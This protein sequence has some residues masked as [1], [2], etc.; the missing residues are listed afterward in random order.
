MAGTF[1]PYHKW[2]GIAADEQPANYY[3]FLGIRAFES[4][5]DVIASAADQRMVHVRSF[6]SGQY[7]ELSQRI[8]NELSAA[9][10]CLL[11][12]EK[13]AVYD[14]QLRSGSRSPIPSRSGADLEVPL[15]G[16]PPPVPVAQSS[17]PILPEAP[18]HIGALPDVGDHPRFVRRV[19][20]T[21]PSPA[22]VVVGGIGALVLIGAL[23]WIMAG[24]GQ[25]QPERPRAARD[26]AE[27]VTARHSVAATES[28]PHLDDD[29]NG[30]MADTTSTDQPE[31]S[32]PPD[33]HPAHIAP[34]LAVAPFA[35]EQ[36]ANHQETWAEH[37][38][39]P[40]EKTN[41]I[42]MK[43][44]LIPPGEFMIG[45]TSKEVEQFLQVAKQQ[46]APQ[47]LINRLPAEAPK[48][49]VRITR[50]FYLGIYEV[51]QAEYERVMGSNPSRFTCNPTRPVEQVIWSNAVEFCRIL[52][53][54]ES[55]QYR[56]PTEAEWEYACRAGTTTQWHF[57]DDASRLD[58]YAWFESNSARQTHPVGQ[59]KPNAWRLFDMYGNV[60][61]W[62]ADW[63]GLRYYANSPTDD[64]P[65]PS[66][67]SERV[68]RGG[69]WDNYASDCRSAARFGRTMS[70]RSITRGFRVVLAT[71]GN[72]EHSVSE[73]EAQPARSPRTSDLRMRHLPEP[74]GIPEES[75]ADRRPDKQ[76]GKAERKPVPATSD[77]Q[78][79]RRAIDRLYPE[80]QDRN[81]ALA[82]GNK[83]AALAEDTEE[84]TERF[85]LLRRASELSSDGG[86]ARRMLQLVGRIAEEFEVDRLLAQAAM[87]D[88]FAKKAPREE[89]IGALV[90]GSAG[91]IDEAIIAEQFDLADE[92]SALVY[93]ACQ[94]SAGREFR[95]DALARRR[96]V[97]GLRDEW[98]KV[99]AARAA[100]QSNPEDEAAHTAVGRWYGVVQA[101]WE[102]AL[103]HFA[104]GSDSGVRKLVD[105]ELNSAPEDAPAQVE[106]AD[107]WWDLAQAADPDSSPV[108]FVRA[109]Y[110]YQQAKP[111]ISNPLVKAKVG[112]RLQ[113]LGGLSLPTSKRGDRMPPPAVAPFDAKQAAQHQQALAKH[114]DVPVEKTNSIGMKFVLIP[115]GEFM[116]GSTAQ[117]VERLLGEARRQKAPEWYFERL[118]REA[119]QHR[120]RISRWFY[121]GLYE[122]T[123][124]Q[125][126]RVM[127]N[128][129]SQFKGNAQLPVERVTWHDAVE[130]CRRLSMLPQ[131][132]EA[133]TT[134]RLPTE[135]E[136]EYA[137]R[138]GTT[139]LYSF[140]DD[141]AIIGQYTWWSGNSREQTQPVGR[142]RPNA[143]GL[144]DMHGNVWEWCADWYGKRY[145]ANSPTDNPAGPASD[146]DRVRR[147]GAWDLHAFCCRSAY[148][149]SR[150]PDV[151]SH[152][153]GFRVALVIAANEWHMGSDTGEQCP[154]TLSPTH[155]HSSDKV[156]ERAAAST[157]F[158]DER[159]TGTGVRDGDTN[160]LSILSG[161]A[162]D[163]LRA[164]MTYGST[165]D[166]LKNINLRRQRVLGDWK[167]G[168][169]GLT[170]TCRYA[171]HA[172]LALAYAP[173][174]SYELHVEFT[175]HGG[176]DDVVV[177][178]P[179]GSTAC[180]L[181]V[182]ALHGQVSSIGK[183]GGPELPGNAPSRRPG[184]LKNDH[185]YVM[186]IAVLLKD[187]WATIDVTLDGEPYLRWT[188]KQSSISAPPDWRLPD[189][190]H[191]GVG[192]W[193]TTVTIHDVRVWPIAQWEH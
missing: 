33:S 73:P 76:L 131:E 65:G 7:S 139:T 141:A 144:F 77:Q 133:G 16:P 130:F 193:N 106:L 167:H 9:R 104:K 43:F 25:I 50:P 55:R 174:G 103:P 118:P 96:E 163:E 5:P 47:W 11:D 66:S 154:L 137:C 189:K 62:C 161:Q 28:P 97:Q 117:E 151:R 127:G 64:P 115:P 58:E 149:N 145:Y 23:V 15:P 32:A 169:A 186:V 18:G 72:D 116:M 135:A 91:V 171:K 180:R 164:K 12:A 132:K 19:K 80:P 88:G 6:Q 109:E 84:P 39:V 107:A 188:G 156:A 120:V 134:Y 160:S 114:L 8:L 70:T 42:G 17:P 128:N 105:R 108:W 59:K 191:L 175:R 179:V 173:V 34:P 181:S 49:P 79:V 178:L 140:G 44:V 142:L 30:A 35:S 110:W 99:Q 60:W 2:L 158:L 20:R 157:Q 150:P 95:V 82:L 146:S 46:G 13:K 166:L 183:L 113:E 54:R 101:D 22:L 90:K 78:E 162:T 124:G 85:V 4:D 83:L 153:S 87:L 3:R 148:R 102:R 89:Q 143:F 111:Q 155:E 75:P 61:E 94:T 112:Q 159:A 190:K 51:T 168:R 165:V 93:R 121:M 184:T 52:S 92:L 122:V 48:H 24:S 192:M 136:W 176:R 1:D 21:N 98:N 36:A 38:G 10:V 27:T 152:S 68:D 172:V 67:G 100:L 14:Q 81:E 53:E 26:S 31:P 69:S 177:F 29:A 119:P 185:R 45:A 37:L 129:P 138:A 57:G 187:Q 170:G 40:V 123:Q 86:D 63:F 147:G 71:A 125:Y 41:S 182:S 56:L 126:E 74:G